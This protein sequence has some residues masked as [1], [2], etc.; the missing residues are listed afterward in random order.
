MKLKIQI[1]KDV[2]ERWECYTGNGGRTSR[3]HPFFYKKKKKTVKVLA[4][5]VIINFFST[6]EINHN[7]EQ[8]WGHFFKKWLSLAKNSELFNFVIVVLQIFLFQFLSPQLWDSL[9]HPQPEMAMKTQS[10][11]ASGWNTTELELPQS[12]ISTKRS[13]LDMCN[14]FL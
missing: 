7:V 4:K 12:P 3:K 9:E 5:I 6:W 1:F 13:L 10:L 14:D 11:E 8:S 2:K